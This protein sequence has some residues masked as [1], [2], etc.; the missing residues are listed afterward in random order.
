MEQQAQAGEPPRSDV[1]YPRPMVSIAQIEFTT[2]CNLKCVYCPSPQKMRPHEH[3]SRENFGHVMK[4][5]RRFVAA[6]TQRDV[7]LHGIGE[8]MLNPDFHAMVGEMRAE[9]PALLLALSSN[10]I[11]LR[12]ENG[13]E[14][15]CAALARNRVAVDISVHRTDLIGNGILNA[16]KFKILKTLTAGPALEPVDWAGQIK[17][18]SA[19]PRRPCHFMRLGHALVYADGRITTCCVDAR[20]YGVFA[21]VADDAGPGSLPMMKLHELCGRCRRVP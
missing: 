14:E 12:T 5:L 20:G 19:E 6:G 9:F 3:L 7:W 15:N 1:T 16:R 8:S 2:H 4:W 17:W 11:L 21:H 13:G 18:A 10:G